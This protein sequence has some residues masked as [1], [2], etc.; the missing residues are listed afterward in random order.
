V[1]LHEWFTTSVSCPSSMVDRIVPATTSATLSAAEHALGVADLAAVAAEPFRQWVLED[2]FAGGR[3]DWG[4]AGALFTTDVAD[5]T[6]WEHLKLRTL[7]G[8]H[9]ALAYLGALA[10]VETIAETLEL[11]GMRDLMRSYVAR[12]VAASLAPPDGVS[13]LSYGD[14]VLERFANPQLGHRTLQVAMDGSQKLPQRVLSVLNAEGVTP[15]VG[16]LILAA[17]AQYAQGRA[18]DGRELPLD[19]PRAAE[20][21]ADLSTAA[22]FGPD[23]MLP[24]ADQAQLAAVQRWRDELARYGAAEVVRRCL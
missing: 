16:P 14:T 10:G 1:R 15:Q 11:P 7:N 24:L 21:R 5:V 9:S 19:D 18:D 13:V 20:I 22:L 17:W 2:D 8:V 3:P 6:A 4:S 23:G 12:E